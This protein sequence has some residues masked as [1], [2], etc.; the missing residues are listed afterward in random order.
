MD[1]RLN[2]VIERLRQSRFADLAGTRA[3]L[4]VPVSERLV[5]EVLAASLPRG[6][7]VNEARIRPHAGNRLDIH[8]KLAR[9]AFLPPLTLGAVIER[10]PEFPHT[11][12]IVLRLTSLPGVMSL[13]GGAA[14]FFNV[15]PPGVRMQGERVI[16]NVAELARQHGR[17]DVLDL[18]RRLHVTTEEAAVLIECDFEI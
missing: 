3:S 6:G 14:T 18:I 8:V 13:A 15:L 4:H 12:E 2:N 5:N 7:A 17:S 10:Q 16:V 11:P 9:P 1:P